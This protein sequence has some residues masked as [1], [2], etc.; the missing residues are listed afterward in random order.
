MVFLHAKNSGLITALFPLP[1][2]VIAAIIIIIIIVT[3]TIMI[4]NCFN[5]LRAKVANHI[6]TSQLI[7]R[8]NQLTGFY[9]MAT[10]ALN[11]LIISMF[12]VRLLT[13]F[14]NT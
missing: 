3:T 2:T 1:K 9:T 4:K 6:E 13:P 8:A 5:T 7:Y 10:L 11:E 14:N 12:I